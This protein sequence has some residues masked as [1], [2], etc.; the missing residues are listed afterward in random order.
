[1]EEVGYKAGKLTAL[2]HVYV[3]PGSSSER[4]FLYYAPVRPKD[5][6]D[7]EAS[8]LAAEKEDVR[9]VEFKRADFLRKLDAGVFEDAKLCAMGWWLKSRPNQ[10]APKTKAAAKR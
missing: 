1:M 10:G 9:R 5:L 6:V 3:S 8:G 4:V 7:P 2:G